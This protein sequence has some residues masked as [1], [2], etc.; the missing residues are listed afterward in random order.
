MPAAERDLEEIGDYI[1]RDN[2]SRALSFIQ[3]LRRHCNRIALTPRGAP[4]RKRL[5]TG[6]R[7]VPHERYGI[8]YR[9]TGRELR[10]LRIIHGARDIEALF[11]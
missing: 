9:V 10:I 6:V 1:A 2:P 4:V 3:E 7:F 8:F 11:T 5:G